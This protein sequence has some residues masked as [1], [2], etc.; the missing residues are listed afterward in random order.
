VCFRLKNLVFLK[1]EGDT[2]EERNDEETIKQKEQSRKI[3]T[4]QIKLISS[5]LAALL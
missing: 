5:L 2:Y 3:N 1:I 4:K